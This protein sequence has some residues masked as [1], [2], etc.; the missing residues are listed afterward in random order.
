M[1]KVN[2]WEGK[3]QRIGQKGFPMSRS[4]VLLTTLLLLNFARTKFRDF[5]LLKK[6]AKINSREKKRA[7]KL[8]SR[9]L[10]PYY[11]RKQYCKGCG[12]R[13]LV[14]NSPKLK[15]SLLY[16]KFLKSFLSGLI[17]SSTLSRLRFFVIFSACRSANTS[18][19]QSSK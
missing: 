6:I 5:R 13:R 12:G 2:F 9:N 10:I 15:L 1:V 16:L 14:G 18:L 3:K 4:C 19:L 11:T 7:R 8:K 17:S